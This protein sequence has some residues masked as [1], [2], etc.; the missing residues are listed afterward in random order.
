MQLIPIFTAE[1]ADKLLSLLGSVPAPAPAPI[2]DEMLILQRTKYL[3]D[4]LPAAKFAFSTRRLSSKY[5]GPCI[6]VARTLD[7]AVTQIGFADD[8]LDT[9]ELM[10]FATGTSVFVQKWYD[11]SGNGL[12]VTY[13]PDVPVIVTAGVLRTINAR[14]ALYWGVVARLTHT[15]STV[16]VNTMQTYAVI[17]ADSF[18]AERSIIGASAAGGF[19]WRLNSA[20]SKMTTL[21][22]ETASIG[23]SATALSAATTYSVGT[24][25][26]GTN[27]K[28]YLSGTLD[29]SGSNAQTITATNI[30][31]GDSSH[32]ERML[33]YIPEILQFDLIGGLTD[34]QIKIINTS[35][36]AYW[37][38]A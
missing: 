31:I 38:S 3:L 36:K 27:W 12:D 33:G 17:N 30:L 9:S 24:F 19:Q 16:P 10:R 18:A 7:S 20:D 1:E 34:A 28:M 21:K 8:H 5:Y 22:Q 13:S 15:L 14:A 6:Q 35:H 29:G 11:Q 32:G 37:A 25:F 26:D 4:N 23:T 2:E